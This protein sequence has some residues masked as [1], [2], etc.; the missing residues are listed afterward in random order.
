M[1]ETKKLRGACIRYLVSKGYKDPRI[2]GLNTIELVK[3][4]AEAHIESQGVK[5][6]VS[7]H[8]EG[9]LK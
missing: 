1:E 7:I 5:G 8:F 9:D 4:V 3:K 6:T 2:V